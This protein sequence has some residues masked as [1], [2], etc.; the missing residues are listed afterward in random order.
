ME[1]KRTVFSVLDDDVRPYATP[2]LSRRNRAISRIL[3]ESPVQS[4]YNR[5]SSLVRCD[6]TECNGKYVTFQTKTLH[7]INQ[8]SEEDSQDTLPN[9]STIDLT[10]ESHEFSPE[11]ESRVNLGGIHESSSEESDGKGQEETEFNLSPRQRVRRYKRP[12]TIADLSNDPNDGF[13][14]EEDMNVNSSQSNNE[15]DDNNETFKIFE[16]YSAPD[17][18]PFQDP[19]TSKSTNNP[20]FLWILLWIMSFRTRFNLPET[21]TES[22][23]KFI[24]IILTEISDSEFD[25]FLNSLY[26]ARNYLGLQDKFLIFVPCPKCH[27]LYQKHEVESFQ[28]NETLAIMECHHIEFPNS[29][30]R[31]SFLCETPLSRQT[32]LLNSH[33]NIPELIYPFNGIRQQ[34]AAMFLRDGFENSLRHWANRSNFDN[35]L[36]DIYD[37]QVW[38]SLKETESETSPKFLC[39]EKADSH[40]GLMLNLDWFQ[41]YEGTI[42]STGVIYAAICN[43]PRDIRFNRENLLILG[44]LP[45]PNEVSLHKINHYLAPIV[46]ELE[47][48]WVGLTL[49]RTYE[50]QEGK[51]IRAALVLVS[52]DIPAARK[53]C[54]HVSALVSC[55][56]CEKKANYE[57]WQHNFAGMDNMN[58]WLICRDS[59]QHRE[60]ALGWRRCNLNAARKRF[61]KQTGVRWSELLRLP[62]FDPIR[63][64]IVDPMHC[65]FLGIARWIVKQLWINTEVL[66]S[67]SLKTIQKKM[68]QFQIPTDVGQILG[69]IDCGE[70][71]SNFTADQWR[72]F[73]AIYATVSLWD[74][75]LA[76]DKK[77]LNNFVRICSILVNRIMEANFINE[78]HQRLVEVVKLIE[79]HYGRDK[80][81]PNLHLSLHLR[82]CIYD[83]GPVY[84]FWCFSFERMNGML[85]KLKLLFGNF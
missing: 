65:L 9:V 56:R 1:R 42:H 84:A 34:L 53:I 6:C 2:S 58:E 61:V 74:H 29:S 45:G 33:K 26:M 85:G 31:R 32:R 13:S 77:I 36:T 37:G 10:N 4:S 47:A 46:D 5:D 57:N 55:H 41:P 38:K 50:Y 17:Y 23:I 25:E 81:T 75:L 82:E 83:F 3:Q 64:I 11:I 59:H 70:G 60:N 8:D 78:A 73:F 80:V 62:Y 76:V 66:S 51:R 21:G 27:K 24:R 19:T 67:D 15:S 68:N 18:E 72:I 35:V 16:D 54:G 43:L 48:L 44:I 69:K 40:L 63:F 79:E 71:F 30:V 28:Q 22:L 39:S 20:Q 7:E 49:N 12:V 52:S 14:T